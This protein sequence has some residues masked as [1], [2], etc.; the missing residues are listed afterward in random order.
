MTKVY[1]MVGT[2]GYAT[3][4]NTLRIAQ[5]LAKTNKLFSISTCYEEIEEE[6]PTLSTKRQAMIELFGYVA[7]K[8]KSLI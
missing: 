1:Y 4:C 5:D 6:K 3:R 2:N 7:P 8:L